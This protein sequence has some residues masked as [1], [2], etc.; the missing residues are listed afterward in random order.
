MKESKECSKLKHE[1]MA[2]GTEDMLEKS[3]AE[4]DKKCDNTTRVTRLSWDEVDSSK[5]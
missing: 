2:P 4:E 1:K 5:T 3:A